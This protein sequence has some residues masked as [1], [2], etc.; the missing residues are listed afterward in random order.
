MKTYLTVWTLVL[1]IATGLVIISE[2]VSADVRPLMMAEGGWVEDASWMAYFLAAFLVLLTTFRHPTRWCMIV[3][4]M[5]FGLRELDCD[6]RFTTMGMFK[7]RYYFSSEVPV[8]E[9]IIAGLVT[10][11]IVAVLFYLVKFHLKPFFRRVM[12]REGASLSFFFA[13]GLMVF[14][15]TIDGFSRKLEPFGIVPSDAIKQ[16]VE[17]VEECFEL[18]AAVFVLVAAMGALRHRSK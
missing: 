15:K 9:K 1:L 3:G 18:A 4:V 7:S 17:S 16:L 5:L 10:A 2:F 11:A 14:T 8:G 12:K 13:G 6:K